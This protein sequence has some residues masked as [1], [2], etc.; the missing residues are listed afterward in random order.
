MM[1]LGLAESCRLARDIGYQTSKDQDLPRF[2]AL[3]EVITLCLAYLILI[4][5]EIDYNGAPEGLY[6]GVLTESK[7]CRV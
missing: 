7:D 1:G 3:D 6:G 5:D 2:G 4:T